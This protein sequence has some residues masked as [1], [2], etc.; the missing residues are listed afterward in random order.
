MKRV[1][2]IDDDPPV[3]RLVKAALEDAGVEH[4]V[5]YCSDG[6]Q[7]RTKAAQGTYDLITLDLHM[8]LM[9]GVEALREAKRN[10]KSADIPIV[11]VTAQQDPA[12]H[13]RVLHFGAA[14]LVRK[15]FEIKALG[16]ILAQVLAGEYAAP[17]EVE[18]DDSD[19]RP[20]GV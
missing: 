12:F 18:R 7:G 3:A 13:R 19:I 1:L 9:G 20:L 15:P 8:P 5:D 2:V 14:A 17:A 4:T 16:G 6:A 11:V 10:P